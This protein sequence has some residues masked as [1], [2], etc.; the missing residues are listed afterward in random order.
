MVLG[1]RQGHGGLAVAQ[2]QE[3][4]FLAHEELLDDE[5][6]TGGT[7]RTLAHDVVHGIQGFLGGHGHH[8]A[9]AGSQAVG[10]DHQGGAQFDHGVLGFVGIGEDLAVGRGHTGAVHDVLGEG[11]AAFQTGTVGIRAET[12]DAGLTHAVGDAL[13]QGQFGTGHHQVD[14]F[15]AGQ[16]HQ[17]V[18][19]SGV[20]GHVDGALTGRTTLPGA[21]KTSLTRGLCLS[22]H[23]RACSRPPEPITRMRTTSPP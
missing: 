20:H 17:T 5:L 4:G 19:V 7:V 12:G 11:L 15:L 13:G 1:G 21:T 2:A 10:L 9:L 8:H 16:F 18:Q 22:F 3:G 14:L 6:G 23:T